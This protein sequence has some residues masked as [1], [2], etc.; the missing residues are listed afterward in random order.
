[1]TNPAIFSG[2]IVDDGKLVNLEVIKAKDGSVH[3]KWAD[4]NCMLYCLGDNGPDPKGAK[5]GETFL[6][7]VW[8]IEQFLHIH[9]SINTVQFWEDREKHVIKFREL[10]GVLAEKVVVN[11]VT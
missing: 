7:K 10:S 6:W 1:M 3:Y 8:L 9:S 5:P 4:P 2:G 11:H